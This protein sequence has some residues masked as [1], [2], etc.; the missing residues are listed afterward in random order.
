M[1]S[2]FPVTVS[3]Y[4]YRSAHPR[5]GPEPELVRVEVEP[6]EPVVPVFIV[7]AVTR[8]VRRARRVWRIPAWK[9]VAP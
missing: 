9:R 3:A 7:H 2:T 8:G 6:R 4:S 1:V 5:I